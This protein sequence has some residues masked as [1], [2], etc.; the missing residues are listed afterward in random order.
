MKRVCPACSKSLG[1]YGRHLTR[2]RG[3][4]IAWF[5]AT[6]CRYRCTHCRTELQARFGKTGRIV[7]C[8]ALGLMLAQLT[9]MLALMSLGP[10][11]WIRFKAAVGGYLPSFMAPLW[12][13]LSALIPPLFIEYTLPDKP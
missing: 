13:I 10:D 9:V 11:T 3:E 4:G 1:W 8:L 7:I 2:T 12:I 5:K 6:A